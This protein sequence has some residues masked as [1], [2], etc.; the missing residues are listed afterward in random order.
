MVTIRKLLLYY[1][2]GELL[3][4]FLNVFREGGPLK[5]SGFYGTIVI[6]VL[7]PFVYSQYDNI[8]FVNV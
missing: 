6:L 7:S 1:S 3:L 4:F 5:M 2:T 8:R